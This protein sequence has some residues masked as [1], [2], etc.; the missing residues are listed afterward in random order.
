MICSEGCLD[1]G[2]RQERVINSRVGERKCGFVIGRL[3]EGE[4]GLVVDFED[5]LDGVDVGG[6][7]EVQ[8]Q[9]VLACRAH[10]L[11]KKAKRELVLHHRRTT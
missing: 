10:D 7:P 1:G 2:R 4:P 8:T 3:C 11:L 6:R 5:L 9:V